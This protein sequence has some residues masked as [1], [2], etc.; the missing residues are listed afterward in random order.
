LLLPGGRSGASPEVSRVPVTRLTALAVL[1]LSACALPFETSLDAVR[2][3]SR[4]AASVDS[5]T[6]APSF[7]YLR[8]THPNGLAILGLNRVDEHPDGPIQVW[9]SV[10]GEVLRIQNG[11]VVG[12]TGLLAEWH[13]VRLP[14]LPTWYE[15][16]SS[17]TPVRWQRERD[18]MPGYRYG[19]HDELSVRTASVPSRTALREFDGQTLT[20]F[21]EQLIP[22]S[23][24][25]GTSS[26]F[27]DL[28]PARYA[29]RIAASAETVVYGEQCLSTKLCITWQRWSAEQ[30]DA[31][32]ER[33]TGTKK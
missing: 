33:S 24:H 4:R 16:A 14:R 32:R 6:L 28:P 30:Q 9:Q 20:W 25:I 15:L 12:A 2:A 19:V 1:V 31:V 17:P 29:V 23:A 21:E 7:S 8:I 13:N 5:A 11:R 27:D 26:D 10:A 3:A 18:V 22:R